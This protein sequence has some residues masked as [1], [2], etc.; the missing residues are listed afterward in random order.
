MTTLEPPCGVAKAVL[1]L[2]ALLLTTTGVAGQELTD[3]KAAQMVDDY[4]EFIAA[5][6]DT[7][8]FVNEAALICVGQ[9]QSDDCVTVVAIPLSV[10]AGGLARSGAKAA[11]PVFEEPKQANSKLEYASESAGWAA[12][13]WRGSRL[14][15]LPKGK[16][17]NIHPAPFAH[18]ATMRCGR[19]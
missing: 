5:S 11:K 13:I 10:A 7:Y 3:R 1:C 18:T 12:G 8:E 16:G 2:I 19:M 17:T 15:R 14:D 4:R 9:P 6:A